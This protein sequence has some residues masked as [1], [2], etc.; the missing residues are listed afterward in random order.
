MRW[1]LLLFPLMAYA[2]EYECSDGDTV[3]VIDEEGNTKVVT[4]NVYID[5]QGKC[6][7]DYRDDDRDEYRERSDRWPRM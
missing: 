2:Q 1:L 6:D 7:Y 3:V 5:T 4:I